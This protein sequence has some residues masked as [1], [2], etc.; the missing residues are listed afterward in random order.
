MIRRWT[1]FVVIAAAG[2]AYYNGIYN[3]KSQASIGDH[4]FQRG[5]V[6]AAT[7]AY[8]ISA[9]T[10][11]TVLVRY[12]KSRW[13]ADALYLAGRGFALAGECGK[14]APRLDEFL[15]LP[16]VP[17]DRRDRALVARGACLVSANQ[18]VE[19][20]AILRPLLESHDSQVRAQAAL[21]A[22]RAALQIGDADR[23]ATLLASVAGATAAW[24]FLNAAVTRGDYATAESLLVARATAGDWRSEVLRDVR[25]LWGTGHRTGA[26]RVA[27]LYGRSRAPTD[28]RVA[29]HLLTSDLA[30]DAG[31]TALARQQAIAA[32][33]IGYTPTVDAEARV[34][35]LAL[36]IRELDALSDITAAVARD[37]AR[38]SGTLLMPR[39][40]DNLII[41]RLLLGNTDIY[42]ASTFM[43]AEIAR[44]SLHNYKLARSLFLSIERDH[45]D[46]NAYLAARGFAAVAAMF[47]DSASGYRSR[48]V[49]RWPSSGAAVAIS[50]GD[51]SASG[52]RA[53]DRALQNAW[54]VVMRQWGD[55][56]KA[57]K[58]ADSLA[59]LRAQGRQ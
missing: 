52:L 57:R 27:N 20:D 5:E 24:E 11:E 19:A 10:A 16:N 36:R 28:Q 32:E 29:L 6:S 30:A 17:A 33:R 55:T 3:A 43:A 58:T 44:D 40:R 8:V 37:S 12:P 49:S 54:S 35:L 13:R 4:Q 38:V 39:I 2:C 14:S 47:P 42:G 59:A 15:A 53:E 31:D 56:L 18:L 46:S 25:L 51:L 21:W 22:G 1:P 9:A 50:G 26:E 7:Q 48:I 41:V 23:A 34:R 45:P